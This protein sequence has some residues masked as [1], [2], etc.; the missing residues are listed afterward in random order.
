MSSAASAAKRDPKYPTR[1][2]IESSSSSYPR[3]YGAIA[4]ADSVGARAPGIARFV[5]RAFHREG[6]TAP[7]IAAGS[8]AI[9]LLNKGL[10][11]LKV[12]SPV[13]S[14]FR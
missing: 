5:P 13:S 7:A 9:G 10:A 1:N 3:P 8:S 11:N 12:C 6:L 14:R 2:H 4:A